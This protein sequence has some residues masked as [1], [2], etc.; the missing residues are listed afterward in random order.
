MINLADRTICHAHHET[1]V[2]LLHLFLIL[3]HGTFAQQ[4]AGGNRKKRRG[5]GA[6]P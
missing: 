2:Q 4:V 5:T 3:K 1:R 6:I